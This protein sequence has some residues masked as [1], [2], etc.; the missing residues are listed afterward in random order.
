M[1]KSF[2]LIEEEL[3]KEA[4]NK[5]QAKVR[6]KAKARAASAKA[7]AASAKARAV[8]AKAKAAKAKAAKAK[9]AIRERNFTE[10]VTKTP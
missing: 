8:A 10:K 4:L 1:R 3:Q 5:K 6:G 2:L 9:A 7:R